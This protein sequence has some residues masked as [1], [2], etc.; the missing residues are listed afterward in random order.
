MTRFLHTADWQIG[1]TR[2]FLQGEAQARFAVARIDAI[3]RLGA[4]AREQGCEFVVVCGDVFETNQP[5]RQT[6]GRT[7][8]ALATIPVP[9]YLLPGNHDPLGPVTVYR[10]PQFLKDCPEHVHVLSSSDPVAVAEGVELIPAPWSG[11]HPDH[12]LVGA[13]VAAALDGPDA[14]DTVRIVVGHGAVDALDP[15][16]ANRAAIALAPLERELAAGRIHYVALGDRHSRTSV[17]DSGAVWFSGAVEVTA[18]RETSPGDVLVVDVEQGQAPLVTPHHVGT[19]AFRTLHRE[20]S[21]GSDVASLARELA[22]L[23]DKDRTV[24]RLALRGQLGVADHADLTDLF[25][26]QGEVFASLYLWER[27]TTLSCTADGAELGAL[28]LGGFLSAAAEEMR[29]LALAPVPAT[30]QADCGQD[31]SEQRAAEAVGGLVSAVDAAFATDDHAGG[32]SGLDD[33]AEAAGDATD[34][35]TWEFVPQDQP[36]SRSATEALELLYRLS[37]EVTR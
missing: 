36:D 10:S 29:S 5:S 27:H 22:A 20:L 18:H 9:V 31:G 16:R 12:D 17:G 28:G 24:V 34:L 30:A 15:D 1:M 35:L 11:K 33:D 23:P 4:V 7:L 13:A 21:T 14:R 26:D 3:I 6:V 25:A 19:W 32:D 2:H 37:G 8:E